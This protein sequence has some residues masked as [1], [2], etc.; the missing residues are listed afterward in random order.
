MQVLRVGGARASRVD[1]L[2]RLMGWHI[3][4]LTYALSIGDTPKFEETRKVGRSL[5]LARRKTSRVRAALGLGLQKGSRP[6]FIQP[7]NKNLRRLLVHCAQYI[8]YPSEA[9]AT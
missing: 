6:S 7:G 4:S 8:I 1:L 5:G 2:R 9:T 3:A